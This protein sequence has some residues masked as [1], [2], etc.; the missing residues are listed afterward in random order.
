MLQNIIFLGKQTLGNN[1]QLIKT[2]VLL[3]I[4]SLNTKT[5]NEKPRSEADQC[6]G[7]LV[8]Q[9]LIISCGEYFDNELW[10]MIT[11]CIT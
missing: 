10:T 6:E 5:A 7:V 8:L 3:C 2:L 1:V 4:E 9:S 11:K